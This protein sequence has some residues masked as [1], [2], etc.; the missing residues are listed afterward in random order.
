MTSQAMDGRSYQGGPVDPQ[1]SRPRP[2]GPP[3]W[4]LSHGMDG[5]DRS[6]SR[7]EAKLAPG[8]IWDSDAG[9]DN[10]RYAVCSSVRLVCGQQC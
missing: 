9:Q 10:I 2:G 5:S 1:G 6:G 8:M 7:Q 3:G 4:S